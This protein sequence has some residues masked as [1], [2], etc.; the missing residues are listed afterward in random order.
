VG[1]ES[2]SF[3]RLP[4]GTWYVDLD[5]AAIRDLKTLG[6][7]AIRRLRAGFTEVADLS[8]LRGVTLKELWIPGTKVTDLAPLKGLPIEILSLEGTAV[9][10][11]SALRGMPL[12]TLKLH[13]CPELTDLAPLGESKGLTDL[14]LPPN[15]KDIEFLRS[16]PKLERLSFT[17]DRQNGDRAKQTA[18]VFWQEYDTLSWLRAL[19]ASEIAIKLV[20]QLPDGTWELDLS[21]TK[22]SDLA[23]LKG[24]LISKLHLRKTA[25]TDLTPLRGMPLTLLDVRETKIADISPLEGMP[26]QKLYVSA[27]G[28]TDLSPL[29]GMSL[30]SFD[31][32]DT[33]IS[34]VS[35]LKGMPIQTL[36]IGGT[37]IT[38][39][40][41]VRGMPLTSLFIYNTKIT[42]LGPLDGMRLTFLHLMGSK[43]KDLSV[44]RGMPLSDVRLQNSTEVTDLSPLSDAT[45]LTNLTL[46]PNAKNVEFLR[47]FTKLARL[48][49]YEGS[50]GADQTAAEFW[51]EYDT[52][53][54]L[55]TLREMGAHPKGAKLLADGTWDLNFG[56]VRISDLTILKGIPIS[57]LSLAETTVTDLTPLRGMALKDIRLYKSKVTDLS[58]LQGMPIG[59]LNISYTKVTDLSA[60]RGMPLTQLK[61]H[62][63]ASLT[64]L[65]PLAEIK[66]LINV[67]LPPGAK[68]IEFLRDFPNL[69]RISYKEDSK[70]YLPRETA[71]EFWQQYD[72]KKK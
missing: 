29:R 41:V 60:V 23:L 58:P 1:V 66:G 53:G 72:A 65:S 21:L 7:V 40:E 71:A 27:T 28:V 42:D 59:A 55:R 25:I 70:S 15:A 19:R 69:E 10:D 11:L 45:T 49:F 13:D 47:A 22:F 30:S 68:N 34:D 48:S 62:D 9:T 46:P 24:A 56:A 5:Y 43:V 52:V 18:A 51:K 37:A 20:R 61:M 14:T 3:A 26:L 16:L 38:D 63:C 67:T 54:W 4:D 17:A 50:I 39:L 2:K 32:R 36:N 33:K 6:G 57:R 31:G 64:D 44:L 35:V 12:T 8:P